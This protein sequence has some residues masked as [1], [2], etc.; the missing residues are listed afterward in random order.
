[1]EINSEFRL[2]IINAKEKLAKEAQCLSTQLY[3]Y[4]LYS[5]AGIN[6]GSCVYIVGIFQ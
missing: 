1:M 3:G 4:P 6:Q 5:H 2:V